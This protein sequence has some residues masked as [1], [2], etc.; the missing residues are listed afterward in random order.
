MIRQD[1]LRTR[2]CS[3]NYVDKI[4]SPVVVTQSNSIQWRTE[5]HQEH[6]C[7]MQQNHLSDAIAV[8]VV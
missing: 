5:S 7:E 1:D 2:R 8:G 3:T 4:T 6:G